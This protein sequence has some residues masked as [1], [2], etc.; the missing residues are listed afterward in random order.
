MTLRLAWRN[1]WRHSRR[2][3]LTTGAMIFSNILLI[4]MISLQFGTYQMMIDNTLQA[5]TGHIQIQSPGYND[6]PKMR[7]SIDNIQQLSMRIREWQKDQQQNS[8][9]ASRASG[10]ALAS[11][12]ERSFGIMI[13]GVEP[14]YEPGVSNI[15]GLIKE[16]RYLK[17]T[18]NEKPANEIVIGKV[19]ASNLKLETGDQVTLLGSGWDGS[20]AAAVV[21]VV[22]IFDSGINELDR[23]VAQ[24]PLDDFQTIFSMESKGHSIAINAGSLQA[25]N[26]L[27][28]QLETLLAEQQ[29]ITIL[30]WDELQPGLK[31]AIQADI[32]SAWFMY[33]ILIILVAFSVLNTQLMSVLE[34]TREFGI[35]MALGVTPGRLGRLVILETALMAAIGLILGVL[36]GLV[37]TYWLSIVGFYYPGMEEMAAKFNLEER[38]YPEISFISLMLGPTVIFLASI[39]ASLYP[40]LRLHMLEPVP[41]MRIA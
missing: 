8:A 37:L 3:W 10:F 14:A 41:A 33:G 17:Q 27:K 30:D 36:L 35:V 29:D 25:V 21:T 13:V 24:M 31:Q 32:A 26:P 19:L 9:V 23:Q 1:L 16:G 12:A 15:P 28:L 39:I 34:R 18:E 6:E 40:A 7:K 2:T 22:G 38:M 20:F 5:F 4:F 11:S